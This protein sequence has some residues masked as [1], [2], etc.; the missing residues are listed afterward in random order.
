MAN[1][2]ID[3]LVFPA[4]VPNEEALGMIITMGFNR[5]QAM[6]A[7]KATENNVERALDWI[8]S[9]IAELDNPTVENASQ[10]PEF[11]DGSGSKFIVTVEGL[12][13]GRVVWFL[14]S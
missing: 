2:L 1:L 9:H 7:L 10:A 8:F 6:K 5:S 11:R 14:A 13:S 4:F 3:Y 12:C